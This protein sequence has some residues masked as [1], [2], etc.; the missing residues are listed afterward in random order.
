MLSAVLQN[1]VSFSG[2]PVYTSSQGSYFSLQ[3]TAVHPICIVSPQTTQDV[4]VAVRALTTSN[5]T[6]KCQ[7]AIRSGGHASFA[8][9]ANIQGGVTIDLSALNEISLEV[10]QGSQPQVSTVSVGA[11]STWGSVYSYLDPLNLSV[12]GGRAASVGVGGL[13]LGGGISYFGPQFGW[14]CDSVANLEVVLFNGSV[15]NV[16]Q[17]ENTDLLWALRGGTN[18]FGIITR[19]SLQTFEQGNLWGGFVLHPY[20]TANKEITALAMF[21]NSD[22]YDEYASLITTFAYVAEENTSLVINN[23]EYTRPVANPPVF[24]ALTSLPTL[25]STQRITNLSDLATET[26]MNDANGF[27]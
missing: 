1:K 24:E 27:R 7:F 2:S 11:G 20:S 25:E 9:A 5:Y 8:G 13:L 22:K 19:V 14:A 12:T 6:N 4:S 17:T 23:M 21:V 10:Q 3:E 15:I 18:N 26:T 16:N